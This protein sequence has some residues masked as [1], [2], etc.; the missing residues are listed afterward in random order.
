MLFLSLLL[1]MP[2]VLQASQAPVFMIIAD[3]SNHRIQR[4]PA[5]S[6]GSACTTVAGT[7]VPGSGATQLKYPI[8]LAIEPS[9]HYIIADRNNHRVQRCPAASFGSACTT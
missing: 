9:G 5:A 2:T 1:T 6:P 7:G 3:S 4:C 8:G